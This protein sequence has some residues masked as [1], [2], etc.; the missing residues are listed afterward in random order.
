MKVTISIF[1]FFMILTVSTYAQAAS[2]GTL[3]SSGPVTSDHLTQQV[4][5]NLSDQV[6]LVWKSSTG[7]SVIVGTKHYKSVNA[8]AMDSDWE[9]VYTRSDIGSQASISLSQIPDSTAQADDFINDSNWTP[10]QQ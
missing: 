10:K 4:Q 2:S 1:S 8:W 3:T 5:I 7:P 6:N 9:G